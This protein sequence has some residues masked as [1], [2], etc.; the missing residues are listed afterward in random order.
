MRKKS[1]RELEEQVGRLNAD[2]NRMRKQFDIM[3][4]QTDFTAKDTRSM[5]H[6][7]ASAFSLLTQHGL[8]VWC[9]ACEEWYTIE[10]DA[11]VG[12]WRNDHELDRGHRINVKEAE[13]EA[14]L[15]EPDTGDDHE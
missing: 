5:I 12:Y 10:W 11:R 2:V 6:R 13:I 14:L 15:S 8:P 3:G 9:E 1:K 7:G 4:I